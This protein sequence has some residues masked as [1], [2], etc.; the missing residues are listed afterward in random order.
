[1]LHFG[2]YLSL[3]LFSH[4]TSII[5]QNYEKINC[6]HNHP[7]ILYS[8]LSPNHISQRICFLKITLCSSRVF[9]VS[10]RIIVK[11]N[12]HFILAHCLYTID[13]VTDRIWL[14][15]WQNESYRWPSC[16]FLTKLIL[17]NVLFEDII[18]CVGKKIGY[19]WLRFWDSKGNEWLPL[20]G[21]L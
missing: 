17:S 3:K 10:K 1:M 2:F 21:E 15:I 14:H 16:I 13:S 4:R 12:F 19:H 8:T 11:N 20:F 5:S 6:N 18:E 9:A 7:I